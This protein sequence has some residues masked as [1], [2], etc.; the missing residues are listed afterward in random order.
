MVRK[1]AFSPSKPRIPVYPDGHQHH[2]AD[3]FNCIPF[4]A[5]PYSPRAPKPSRQDTYHLVLQ[6]IAAVNV[7][8]RLHFMLY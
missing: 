2:D 3:A 7:I 8:S 4:A 5:A 1:A 6:A